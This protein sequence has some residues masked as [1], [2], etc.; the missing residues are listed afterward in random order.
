MLLLG[1]VGGLGAFSVVRTLT[2]LAKKQTEPDQPK[3]APPESATPPPAEEGT[4]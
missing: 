2:K 1:G 3:P 4:T